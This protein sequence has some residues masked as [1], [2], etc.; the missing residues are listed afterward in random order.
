LDLLYREADA[1]PRPSNWIRTGSGEMRGRDRGRKERG[2]GRSWAGITLSIVNPA[3]ATAPG[4]IATHS[5]TEGRKQH[6]R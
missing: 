4:P 6:L 3:N 1:A 5:V 2:K